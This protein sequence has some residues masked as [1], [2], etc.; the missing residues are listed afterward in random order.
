MSTP[1]P[2]VFIVDDDLSV[3]EALEGL[4][5]SAGWRPEGCASA[6]EFLT[7]PRI[8]APS[9]LLLDITLPGLDG[10]ALQQRLAVDRAEMPIIIIT[11]HRDVPMTVRAMKAGAVEF[12]M[13]PLA[14]E[15]VLNAVG[16]A[17]ERSRQVLDREAE[18]RELRRRYASLSLRE[19]EVLALVVAGLLNKQ[20]GGRLGISEITVKAHRGRVMQKMGAGSLAELVT[21]AGSLRLAPAAGPLLRGPRPSRPVE[22]WVDGAWRRST[23]AEFSEAAR[24]G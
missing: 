14:G 15:V 6:E 24:A 17:L 1:V 18:G 4:I 20:V 16:E 5:H 23:G 8:N 22:Q 7:R 2:T 9:C 21:M 12:L 13:K 19:R 11:G 10:L 3:R